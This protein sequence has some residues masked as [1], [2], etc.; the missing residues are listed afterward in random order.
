MKKLEH[1]GIPNENQENNEN[2]V[3]TF[4]NHENHENLR[5][6]IENCKS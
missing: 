1:L 6:P 4:K 5:I 2:H 3:I